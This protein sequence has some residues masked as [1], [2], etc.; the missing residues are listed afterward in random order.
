MP[1]NMAAPPR[2]TSPLVSRTPQLIT[3]LLALNDANGGGLSDLAEGLGI[4]P[5]TLLHYRSGR[6]QLSAKM[7]A[8]IVRRYGHYPHVRDLA[9]H[10]LASEFRLA[11]AEGEA[12]EAPSSLPPN[13]ARALTNYVERFAEETLHGGRGLYLL[14]SDAALSVAVAFVR[15]RFASTNVSC[16]TLRASEKPRASQ[17]RSALAAPLLII[18]RIDFARS[19]VVEVARRRGEILRPLIVTSG[20]PADTVA[21]PYL[22]RILL[23]GTRAVMVDAPQPDTSTAVADTL[24]TS[25]STLTH[26][27]AA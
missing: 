19:T 24:A 12:D 11:R 25:P 27:N 10:Y 13:A 14:G 8:T 21:D 22:R 7:L 1:E 26:A 18:E 23:A 2:I 17:L 5:S 9:L 20:A 3:E 16:C 6:R 15:A 4:D